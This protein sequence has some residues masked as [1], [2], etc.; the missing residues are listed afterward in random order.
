MP[1]IRVGN[2]VVC[3]PSELTPL[4]TLKL[5]E[6]INQVAPP[7]LVNAVTGGGAVGSALSSHRRI[8]KI[9]FTGSIAMGQKI[10]H[11]AP[12]TLKRLPLELGGNDA[13]IGLETISGKIRSV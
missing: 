6:L 3:K 8:Q 12:G 7:G 13:G 9:C 10:M 2:V 1:A 5:I 11:S 4:G